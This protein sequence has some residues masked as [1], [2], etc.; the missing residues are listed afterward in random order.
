M[1]RKLL[2]PLAATVAA[3]AAF[4]AS[5]RYVHTCS[6]GSRSDDPGGV[7][8][9]R[10]FWRARLGALPSIERRPTI[11]EDTAP[12]HFARGAPRRAHTYRHVRRYWAKAT[13]RHSL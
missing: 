3:G 6:S 8:R 13:R 11:G 5:V 10:A 12:A 9:R 4:G 1:M 2:S 7:E